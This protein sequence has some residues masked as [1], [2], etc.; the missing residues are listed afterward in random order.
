MSQIQLVYTLSNH[1]DITA[2]IQIA[3]THNPLPKPKYTQ[4]DLTYTLRGEQTTQKNVQF[5]LPFNTSDTEINIVFHDNNHACHVTKSI[6][7]NIN[8]ACF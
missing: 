5:D 7:Y 8:Y 4:Q 6:I 1:V 3:N 2:Q